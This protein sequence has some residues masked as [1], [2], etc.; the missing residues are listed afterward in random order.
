MEQDQPYVPPTPPTPSLLYID[1]QSRHF[2][3]NAA[4]WAKFLAIIGFIYCFLIV[5]LAFFMGTFLSMFTDMGDSDLS[6]TGMGIFT[7]GFM[8]VLL[9]AIAC[10]YFFPCLYLY[11]FADKMQVALRNAD[12]G[13]LTGSF[14]N[15]RANLRFMGILVIVVISFYVLLLI[16]SV[17]IRGTM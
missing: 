4:T 9:I 11:R 12:Q 7:G 17:V 14:Q 1:D 5:I 3:A 10:L 8:T 6:G 13:N 16:F 2:L 15:L